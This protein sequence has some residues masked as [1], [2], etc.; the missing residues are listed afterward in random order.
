MRKEGPGKPT[1]TDFLWLDKERFPGKQ[2]VEE[3]SGKSLSS[4]WSLT[5]V[6]FEDFPSTRKIS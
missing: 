5:D 4:L 3:K 6:S 2:Q 1:E